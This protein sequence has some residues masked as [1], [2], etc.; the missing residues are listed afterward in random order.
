MIVHMKSIEFDLEIPKG[1]ESVPFD[2]PALSASGRL[3]RQNCGA[4]LFGEIEL[5]MT[6]HRGASHFAVVWAIADPEVVPPEYFNPV[7]EGIR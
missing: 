4:N 5:A 1:I 2:G 6:S 3:S 7:A